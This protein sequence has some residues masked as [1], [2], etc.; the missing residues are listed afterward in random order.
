MDD[1]TVCCPAF[2]GY[3]DRCDLIVGIEGLH[4][5]AA[6][7]D[8]R[9]RLVVTVESE[10]VVMGCP[11]CG[12]VARGHGRDVVE[13]VDAP[14]FGAAVRIRWRKRRWVCP[15]AGCPVVS[16]VEQDERVAAPR[17]KLTTRACRWAIE[18]IRREHASVNGVR[19]QLGTSWSTV[20]TSIEPILAAAAADES[21]F[22]GV[23]ILGVDE[24][25]WHHVSTKPIEDGGR[26]PKELTGMVDLTR[27]SRGNVQ[28]RLLDLVPGRSGE[29]YKTW[30]H[31][32][33][34]AFRSSVEIA[35]LDPFHGYKN[36]V[37]DQLE[38][39]RSVLDAFHVV[40][41]ATAVVDDV[42]RRVQQDTTGHRGRRGDPLYRVRNIL[43]AGQEHLTDRQRA[44]LQAAFTAR[45]EHLEVE[46]AYRCAQQVRA[47]YHQH[48]LAAGRAVAEKIVAT[49]P[50]CP[51]P[52][53]ARLGKT[54][55]RW[56]R[57]FL[58]YFDTDGASNGGTEAVNGLIELHRR[59]ARGLRIRDNYR[60]RMLLIAGGL[61][62]PNH[63]HP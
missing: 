36:A 20:W 47:A 40:K 10:P 54:L 49:L 57:E 43:R 32:R 48:T 38:D 17:S 23:R 39:A 35:T 26:G 53:V 15:D 3:C 63:A 44:C 45:E 25:V 52:E 21:R 41:L 34:E 42:R 31:Q 62:I 50:T 5:T 46:L 9:G 60:L 2:G 33:G 19:R 14:A 51:I 6:E 56:R 27:D 22:E 12:V 28:A 24:H 59:I 16:F 61:P 11:A 30:L 1:P 37:D 13:L 58:G 55:R 18:Q 8:D 29:T 4:V 7:R